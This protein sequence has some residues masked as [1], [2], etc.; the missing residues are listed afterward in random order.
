MISKLILLLFVVAFTFGFTNGQ[1]QLVPVLDG[2]SWQVTVM[3]GLGEL[4][5]PNPKKQDIVDHGFIEAA[6][7]KWQLW[8]CIRGTAAGRI[9][10]RWE[11]D[12]LT[13]RNWVE[14]GIALRSD[15]AWGEQAAPQERLQ[16]PHFMKIGDKYYCFYNSKEV[17][18]L[19]STDG[20]NYTRLPDGRGANCLYHA[21]GA[22]TGRDVMIMKDGN[23]YY[24]Y[25]T[26]T[27]SMN[28]DWNGAYIIVRTSADL[29]HWSD[30]TIVSEGGVAGNGPVSAE[31]PFVVK[32]NNLYYLFRASS[33]TFKTYVYC[34]ET[35]YNFGVNNDSKLIA[36]L[37]LKASELIQHKGD[38]YISD[39][40]DFR[41]IRMYKLRWEKLK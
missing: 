8:A 18:V 37:P 15:T 36:E 2:Q 12:S 27:Y 41:G 22:C 9:L 26:I 21:N 6:T 32:I 39:L 1:N 38:W 5:G 35:P 19:T 11:A 3:P 10:Y 30:Y 40:A 14:K 25:S 24:L 4:N 13:Q 7:G 20:E 29:I 17:R 28:G 33:I 16:A 34:S 23:L 31:S